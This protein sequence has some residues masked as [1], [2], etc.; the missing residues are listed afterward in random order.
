MLYFSLLPSQ[1]QGYTLR[2]MLIQPILQ[3]FFY[4]VHLC[5]MQAKCI[6]FIFS[7]LL[8]FI[9][10]DN[11][12]EIYQAIFAPW[13]I[14]AIINLQSP[15]CCPVHSQLCYCKNTNTQETISKRN[16][17]QSW[18]DLLRYLTM[19]QLFLGQHKNKKI[20]HTNNPKEKKK[21]IVCIPSLHNAICMFSCCLK[22]HLSTGQRQVK[23]APQK[24]ISFHRQ[25]PTLLD[26]M[27]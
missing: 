11:N 7:F 13:T 19:I 10:K 22:T 4:S 1:E 24:C 12:T 3:L 25:Q 21:R 26:D 17:Y 23:A 20:R 2:G 14:V 5:P 15:D 27:N 8:I 16:Q 6:S 9:F 18:Y